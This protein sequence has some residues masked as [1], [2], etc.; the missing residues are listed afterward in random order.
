MKRLDPNSQLVECIRELPP[1]ER[2]EVEDFVEFLAHRRTDRNLLKAAA[3]LTSAA[4]KRI[5]N[6]DEDAA[7]DRL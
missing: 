3:R 2:A 4:L 1:Q 7:Y 5:W 6:N